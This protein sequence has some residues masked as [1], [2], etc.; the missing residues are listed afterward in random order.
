MDASK[1]EFTRTNQKLR[2]ELKYSMWTLNLR[3]SNTSSQHSGIKF[4]DK[5]AKCR[6]SEGSVDRTHCHSNNLKYWCERRS[7]GGFNLIFT[8]SATL[9]LH[10]W[11]CLPSSGADRHATDRY[12]PSLW[13][14]KCQ[15]RVHKSPQLG[16]TLRQINSVHTLR[17]YFIKINFNIITYIY[18]LFSRVLPYIDLFPLSLCSLHV[19][20]NSSPSFS[21]SNSIWWK[22]TDLLGVTLT[23]HPT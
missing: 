16:C 6:R 8:F 9:K 1:T 3:H 15:Y 7:Y 22:Y 2:K 10:P 18:V 17:T 11:N 12:Q 14:L 20:P 4:C 5:V 23:T 19:S 21:H 13:S